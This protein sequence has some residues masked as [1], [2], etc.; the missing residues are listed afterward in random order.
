M[1]WPLSGTCWEWNWGNVW[2]IRVPAHWMI[3][4]PLLPE[5]SA[6]EFYSSVV[7]IF[8]SDFSSKKRGKKKWFMLRMFQETVRNRRKNYCRKW[9]FVLIQIYLRFY[10]L[11][12]LRGQNK[13]NRNRWGIRNGYE[14][15]PRQTGC[16][17]KTETNVSSWQIN[18]CH[19][20]WNHGARLEDEQHNAWKRWIDV[21]VRKVY[22]FPFPNGFLTTFG[23]QEEKKQNTFRIDW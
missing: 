12:L 16:Y 23:W 18:A 5:P 15:E 3:T 8:S 9:D 14:E 19:E 20:S 21:E 13:R 11:W 2:P 22:S 10:V 1:T 6:E 17:I 4:F 7:N